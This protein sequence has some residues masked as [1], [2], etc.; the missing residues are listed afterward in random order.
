LSLKAPDG[1]A[2]ARSCSPTAAKRAAFCGLLTRRDRWGL[3][4][5]GR[6]LLLTLVAGF[7]L[8]G[9]FT[10]YPFLAVTQR[11][12]ANVLVVEGWVHPYA[13]KSAADEFRHGSYYCI[14]TTGGPVVGKGG[15]INDYNTAASVGADLLKKTDVPTELIKIVP[16]RVSGRDRTY[17]SALALKK[18]FAEHPMTVNGINIVTQDVHARRTRLLFQKALGSKMAVG[19]IA[20]PNPDY[21]SRRWWQSSEAAEEIIGEA[22]GYIYA[23]LFVTIG[24]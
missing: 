12:N 22:V 11:V 5:R 8:L 15:Y 3:S 20:V 2:D 23:R 6:C 7:A 24:A 14:I 9:L 16:S 21:D 19:V 13:I 1:A 18:W 10:V 17:N 4:L